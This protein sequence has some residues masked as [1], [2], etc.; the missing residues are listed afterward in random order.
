MVQNAEKVLMTQI[1]VVVVHTKD[2]ET[3][4]VHPCWKEISV[5]YL[6]KPDVSDKYRCSCF[7][8]RDVLSYKKRSIG[9]QKVMR[10]SRSNHLKYVFI[11]RTLTGGGAERFVATFASFMAEQ[12][13]DIYVLT[14]EQSEKEYPLS[15]SVKRYVMPYVEDSAKGKILRIWR[16][17]QV[18]REIDPDVLI[19][20]I[21]TVV[22]CT[23]CAN[24]LLGKKFV[25]TVRNSPWHVADSWLSGIMAKTADGIMLQNREQAEFFPES[26]L[27]RSYIVPNPVAG[28]FRL[29]RKEQ[30]TKQLTKI[31]S[32]GRL[33]PQKNFPLLISAV[34]ALRIR[35]P[36][37]SLQI[38]GEG[39]ER[40]RL[41]DLIARKN[42][43]DVCQLMGRTS[44]VEAVLNE[45]DLFVM[46]SDYEGM[47]NALIEAMAMG[48]PCISSDCRTGPKSLIKDGQ[49]GLLFQTGN[50]ESLTEKMDW[51]LQHPEEMNRMGNNAREDVMD[52]YQIEKTLSAFVEMIEGIYNR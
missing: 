47:P 12:G 5:L 26:Y 41:E 11:T 18:L 13:Y 32:L 17:F 39:E 10:M 48:V 50:L 16:M 27:E 2:C 1:N 49:T 8:I 22:L 46:S 9:D 38:Y 34:E 21:D 19:P 24:M 25:Y 31:C 23:F 40:N 35:H 3:E 15:R 42:L 51:A 33:H 28:K 4:V 45:T 29:C 6:Q 30:Y 36:G 44:D 14:Y 7:Y 20:F 37:I 52:T 43:S